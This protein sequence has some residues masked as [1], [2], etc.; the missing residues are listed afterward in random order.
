MGDNIYLGDR[1]GVRTP[2]QWSADR[3]GGF[4]RADPQRLYLPVIMDPV[5]GYQA[6]NVEAQQRDSASLLNWMRRLIAGQE[7]ARAFGRGTLELPL[8]AQPQGPVPMS[9]SLGDEQILCVANLAA[10]AQAADLDLS[11][12][13]RCRAGRTA[14]PLGLPADRRPA[15]HG[16]AAGLRLLLVPPH[17]RGGAAALV[18]RAGAAPAR[19]RHPGRCAMVSTAPSP[20][21]I[22]VRSRPMSCRNIC[23]ANAGS[24]ARTAPSPRPQSR[25]RRASN[26]REPIIC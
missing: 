4:S 15:L 9:A 23:R 2:M 14:R 3:N 17:P 19:I 11:R 24:P 22:S 20:S 21:A 8:P 13:G 6:V 18:H 10:S 12:L 16:D 1:D 25:C 5:Y 7:A 26:G